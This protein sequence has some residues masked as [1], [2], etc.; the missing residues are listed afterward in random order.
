MIILS[1]AFLIV[2]FLLIGLLACPKLCKCLL[3]VVLMRAR[4][5][6]C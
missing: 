2:L 1:F 6:T 3:F 5:M 4:L